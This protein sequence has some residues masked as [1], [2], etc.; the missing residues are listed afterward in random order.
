LVVL[1]VITLLAINTWE[2]VRR[3]DNDTPQK[4][5]HAAFD[6]DMA[7]VRRILSLHPE[8]I[9]ARGSKP[10]KNWVGDAIYKTV[11][12]LVNP[13]PSD[14]DRDYVEEHFL[15]LE[16]EGATALVHALI[17]CKTNTALFLVEQGADVQIKLGRGYSLLSHVI[18]TGDTN[19]LIAFEK[20]GLSYENPSSFELGDPMVLASW[21]NHPGTLKLFI[22]RGLSMDVTGRDGATP[23][24][25]AV[26]RGRLDFV[27]LL[28]TSGADLHRRDARG[29]S[30]LS[31]ARLLG[32]TNSA[33]RRALSSWLQEYAATNNAA[34]TNAP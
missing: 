1:A 7:T 25:I 32:K 5:R 28:A 29:S 17:R 11:D 19:L 20:R 12:K 3:R 24:H 33:S 27:Q 21:A 6:D 31:Q 2:G 34:R 30:P 23:L 14:Y 26:G 22:D 4:L 10:K 13:T 9:D 8:W 18:N 16:A 15:G